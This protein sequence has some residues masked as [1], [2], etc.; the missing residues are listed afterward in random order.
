MPL[1]YHLLFDRKVNPS[2]HKELRPLPD[3]EAQ[4]REAKNHIKAHLRTAIPMWLEQKLGEKPSESPR[5]R[6]QGSWAYETC[7]QPCQHPPQ[8]MDWDLGIYLPVSLWEEND[9][10]P[11]QAA[12]GYYTMVKDLM[13]PLARKKGWELTEKPTCVRVIL[14]NQT[15]AHVDL[16]LYAAPDAEFAHIREVAV[17]KAGM[18]LDG[19]SFTESVGWESFSRIALACQDGTWNPSDPYLVVKWFE[20]KV[21]RHGAQIRRICRYLKAWR[22]YQWSSGGPSS[23]VLMVCAAQTFDRSNVEFEGRDDLALNHVLKSLPDQLRGSVTEAMINPEEDLNRLKDVDRELAANRAGAFLRDLDR[24]LAL[25]IANV[26]TGIL[27]IQ[28]HLGDRLPFEP[29]A[30][31]FDDA[32]RSIRTISVESRPRQ[33]IHSTRAG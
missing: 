7:N 24:A 11:K 29:Q 13:E 18:T 9:V 4:L 15:R 12:K 16:P 31:I 20:S 6:T 2:F 28:A 1:N 27:L 8:E 26:S 3:E 5:F 17:A 14:G 25:D 33:T 22:D 32:H 21:K 23:I 30:V 10:H 19:V